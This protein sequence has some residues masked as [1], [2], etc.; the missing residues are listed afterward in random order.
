MS[1]V[2]GS[3]AELPQFAMTLFMSFT[4]DCGS[5]GSKLTIRVLA[6]SRQAKSGSSP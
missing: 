3:L 2:A 1:P 6:I 4:F 5:C